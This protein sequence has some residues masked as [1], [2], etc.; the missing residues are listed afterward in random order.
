MS[1]F[2][3]NPMASKPAIVIATLLL[4]GSAVLP[5]SAIQKGRTRKAQVE[6]STPEQIY[7]IGFFYYNNNEIKDDK[8]ARQF[9][10]VI[11][12][13]PSSAEAEKAQFFLGSYYHRKFNMQRQRSVET[14]SETLTKARDAYEAYIKK[15]PKG[16]PCECLS[17][18]YF[19]LSIVHMQ[20]RETAQARQR[21]NTMKETSRI[22]PTVY[23]YQVI[24]SFSSK[25]IIDSHF[26]TVNLANYADQISGL[27][28]D[29]FIKQLKLW[30]MSQKS[31][32]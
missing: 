2:S 10:Y 4:I 26:D 21:L 23:V 8:A 30:C 22:D 28:T 20:L 32:N 3:R 29:L 6:G 16:G 18:A 5:A 9:Q 25:D 11:D 13:F 17:D 15:Y 19:N 24:W 27:D 31:R 14:G 7:S 1:N 12:K